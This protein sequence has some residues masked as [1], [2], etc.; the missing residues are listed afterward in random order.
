M[1]GRSG[2][3]ERALGQRFASALTEFITGGSVSDWPS[4]ST[5]N[6]QHFA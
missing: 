1:L 5:G 2:D 6:V 4:Y 3:A